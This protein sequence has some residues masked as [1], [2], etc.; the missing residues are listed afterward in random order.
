MTLTPNDPSR[1]CS[2]TGSISVGGYEA[3]SVAKSKRE[4]ESVLACVCVLDP[5][6]RGTAGAAAA[7]KSLVRPLPSPT[8]DP[9]LR[10]QTV[11][12]RP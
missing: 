5:P 3:K 8:V 2:G 12:K 11:L 9:K 1:G 4:S 6:D 7:R 10:S